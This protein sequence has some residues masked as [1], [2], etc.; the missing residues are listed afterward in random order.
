MRTCKN[1]SKWCSYSAHNRG[2]QVTVSPSNH[3]CGILVREASHRD[4]SRR[5][6]G[7]LQGQAGQ[8]VEDDI[9]R[10]RGVAAGHELAIRVG[11]KAVVDA[12]GM[13]EEAALLQGLLEEGMVNLG[14]GRNGLD[15]RGRPRFQGKSKFLSTTWYCSSAESHSGALGFHSTAHFHPSHLISF[16]VQFN[17]RDNHI[18]KF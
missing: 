13:R 3:T 10:H 1:K 2:C 14:R 5:D 18:L 15:D 16:L 11:N 8:W 6:G 17:V 7:G 9:G 4:L 12:Q